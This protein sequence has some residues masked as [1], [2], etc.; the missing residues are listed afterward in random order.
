MKRN[1]ISVI[2]IIAS[3]LCFGQSKEKIVYVFPDSVEICLDSCIGKIEE[4]GLDFQF[5]LLLESDSSLYRLSIGRYT[6]GEAN[7]ILPWIKQSNRYAVVNN[8]SL[9]LIFDYDLNFSTK[10]G[11]KIGNFKE[12][13]GEVSRVK[14]LL[15][16]ITIFFNNY[17]KIVKV[18]DL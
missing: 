3:T 14:L 11:D 15:H 10:W 4:S 13:E 12:R 16:G 18:I 6:K 17:G 9:P 5:Y 8:R 1:F 2:A 7:N